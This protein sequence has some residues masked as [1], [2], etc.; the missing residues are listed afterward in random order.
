MTINIVTQDSLREV[1]SYDEITG[2]MRWTRPSK[3]KPQL[4]GKEV[5]WLNQRGYR[6]VII[7][8][9]IY[10][11]H[12]LIWLYVYGTFPK[13]QIDHTNR[14]KDD[15]RIINLR[16]VTNQENCKNQ[17]LRKTNTSGVMGVKLNKLKNRWE[18]FIGDRYLGAFDLK[19]DAIICRKKA[20]IEHNYHPN[21]GA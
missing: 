1:V 5:G 6:G 11:V 19:S 14:I 12:R 7:Q 3:Y 15:N 8:G 17:K 4:T 9:R 20:E 13:D 18:A 16:D 10:L 21:H 2:I